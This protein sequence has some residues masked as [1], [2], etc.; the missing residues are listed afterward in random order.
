M[1]SDLDIF[2]TGV[3]GGALAS[4]AIISVLYFH[5]HSLFKDYFY[6]KDQFANALL[7]KKLVAEVDALK[8]QI[9]Q[10]NLE[11]YQAIVEKEYK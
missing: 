10:M 4:G 1:L 2:L 11:H 6:N 9:K 5:F 3:L 7:V 8:A